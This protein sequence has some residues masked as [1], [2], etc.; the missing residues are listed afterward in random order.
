[1]KLYSDHATKGQA[2]DDDY[3]MIED[4]GFRVTRSEE[5]GQELRCEPVSA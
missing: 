4:L 1:M 5:P 3:R 2:A